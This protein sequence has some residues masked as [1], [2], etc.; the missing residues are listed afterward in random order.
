MRSFAVSL[1]LLCFVATFAQAEVQTKVIQYQVGDKTFD[2]FLAYD[3]AIKGPRPGVVVFHEWWGLNDYAKKRTKM[4]AEL[5]YVAFAADMYGDGKFVD[6]PKDAGEMAGKVRA[7]VAEW[8]KRATVALDILKKQ[9]QCDPEKLAAIGYCF[10]GSTALELAYTGA[11]LD[12]VATFHAALPTPTE[13]QA[14]DIKAKVL[15]CHGADDGFVPQMAIDAFKEKLADAKVDLDFVAFP[16]AVHSFTVEDSGKHNNPGMQYNKA[17]D[18][19]SW[20]MLL[21]LLKSTLGN[22]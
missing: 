22:N 8:Q 13:E 2:G 7:N 1:A 21:D 15:V 14:E 17:A 19:K 16:G 20:A 10:G 5:G 6:H 11:D 18:E 3:D 12:A 4:L 9:P